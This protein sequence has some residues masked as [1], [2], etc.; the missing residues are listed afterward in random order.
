MQRLLRVSGVARRFAMPYQLVGFLFSY[1]LIPMAFPTT[2]PP[3]NRPGYN[4]NVGN[5]LLRM[6]DFDVLENL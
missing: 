2:R 1:N 6:A 5:N 3:V 4:A